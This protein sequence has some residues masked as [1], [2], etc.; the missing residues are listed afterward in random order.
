MILTYHNCLLKSDDHHDYPIS[1]EY[2]NSLELNNL[3]K[4]FVNY[5]DT[6]DNQAVL[7][8]NWS[9]SPYTD[10]VINL[11][12]ESF[13]YSNTEIN[14]RPFRNPGPY[15]T[16]KTFKPLLAGQAFLSVGQADTY[17]FLSNLGFKVNFGF[18]IEFDQDAGDLSR[19]KLIF[20]TIDKIK[21]TSV[22]QLQ[23][24]SIESVT[25]NLQHIKSK[26]LTDYVNVFNRKSIE[27]IIEYIKT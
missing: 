18:N 6:F 2:L 12:N 16:E 10:A 17:K 22:R 5:K 19:I 27:T 4:V 7:N 15:I 21:N 26:N 9:L 23:D 20:E 3:T 14:G 25:H 13:H 8:S 1:L 11:T 24:Q